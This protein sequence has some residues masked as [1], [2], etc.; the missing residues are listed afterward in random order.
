MKAYERKSKKSIADSQESQLFSLILMKS[1]DR[2][3]IS[4]TGVHKEAT[5]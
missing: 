2:F 5:K 3:K 4:T 1:T